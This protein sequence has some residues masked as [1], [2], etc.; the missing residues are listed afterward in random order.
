MSRNDGG[1]TGTGVAE[2]QGLGMLNEWTSRNRP[3]V[4]S[5]RQL[6]GRRHGVKPN[7]C[8]QE[9]EIGAAF[10]HHAQSVAAQSRS[11]RIQSHTRPPANI[12]IH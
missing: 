6:P 5:M 4:S 1:S 11:A 7:Q 8:I 12:V 2:R 9:P 10:A 3:G